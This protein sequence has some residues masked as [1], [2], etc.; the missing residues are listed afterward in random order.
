MK[1]GCLQQF[2]D[3]SVLL[4]LE[5]E[6]F[7]IWPWLTPT[8]LAHNFVTFLKICSCFVLRMGLAP[9][10]PGYAVHLTSH[11]TPSAHSLPSSA[12]H[13]EL[14][15]GT[16][17]ACNLPKCMQSAQV[18]AICSNM[19]SAVPAICSACNPQCMQSAVHTICS[20]FRACNLPK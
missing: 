8:T 9:A 3:N 2:S 14:L 11:Q 10:T 20:A 4:L 7:A 1:A 6:P 17:M 16:C 15:D 12:Y 5:L 19:Q 18:H 13:P